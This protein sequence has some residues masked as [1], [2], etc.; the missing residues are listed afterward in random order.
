MGFFINLLEEMNTYR[1]VVAGLTKYDGPINISGLS[2]SQKAH[3]C[4]ALCERI[5]TQ[6]IYITHD[7]KQAQK[8]FQD[9]E[10]YFGEKALYFSPR[11]LV[12][13]DVEA[14]SNDDVYKRLSTLFKIYN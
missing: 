6:A 10:L 1:D 14:R 2:D 9:F 13:Y 11:D 4:H 5:G 12:M 3:F 8:A 7:E